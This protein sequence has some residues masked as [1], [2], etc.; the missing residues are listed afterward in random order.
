VAEGVIDVADIL[1]LLAVGPSPG[2]S[3][4]TP[5][6]QALLLGVADSIDRLSCRARSEPVRM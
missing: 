5:C 3:L 1:R 4:L 2:R 6:L